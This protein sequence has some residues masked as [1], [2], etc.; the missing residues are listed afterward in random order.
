MTESSV[1]SFF[2]GGEWGENVVFFRG[3][4]FTISSS[5][6]GEWR[7]SFDI[8]SMYISVQIGIR[9]CSLID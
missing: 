5:L 6:L 9:C 3:D 7:Y 1:S 8:E 4:D 2:Y